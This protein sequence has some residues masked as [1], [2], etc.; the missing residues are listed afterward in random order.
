MTAS[1][2]QRSKA[3]AAFAEAR[4]RFVILRSRIC[5]RYGG[6]RPFPAP[7]SRIGEEAA[8]PGQPVA[9]A[10]VFWKFPPAIHPRESPAAAGSAAIIR[11]AQE[12]SRFAAS[13]LSQIVAH[14]NTKTRASLVKKLWRTIIPCGRPRKTENEFRD[15]SRV[16]R[17]EPDG[18]IPI[19]LA[20]LCLLRNDTATLRMPLEVVRCR[21][22][23]CS[24]L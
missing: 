4:C 9:L 23:R 21:R 10:H 7:K 17:S 1:A 20:L 16:A 12:L 14:R 3:S 11:Q 5:N 2:R 8:T 22:H 6:Q 18:R 24:R 15:A 13:T 19:A